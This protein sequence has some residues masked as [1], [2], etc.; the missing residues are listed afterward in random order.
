VPVAAMRFLL[1]GF[2]SAE[3]SVCR[4]FKASCDFHDKEIGGGLQPPKKSAR[5][6]NAQAK[7]DAIGGADGD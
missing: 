4:G 2:H 7:G 6:T 3:C 5:E 1:R